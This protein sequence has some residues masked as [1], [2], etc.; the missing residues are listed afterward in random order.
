MRPLLKIM[1]ALM[2]VFIGIFLL[3]NLTGIVTVTRI[4][5]WLA[6]ARSADPFLVGAIVAALLLAD[7]I[8]AVPTMATLLLAGYF[9]G[10]VN[11]ALAGSVGLLAAGL[12]GYGLGR[13]YGD[14][15]VLRLVGGRKEK[16][17]A[18]RAF[19]R[20][21]PVMI[22]LAR[23]VP[24]LPEVS[25]CMAGV[26]GMPFFRFLGLWLVNVVPYCAVAAYAGSLSSLDDPTP[27][28]ATALGMSAFLW[29]AW[30]LFNRQQSSNSVTR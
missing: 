21:G 10:A 23:A 5:A 2:L 7:L 18:V 14:A 3:L 20:H 9:I 30:A 24:M 13:R 28:V 8:I 27:A 19:Q 12:A 16:E 1:G 17:K 6:A 11:G 25:A 15:A 22:V 29:L 4:E 26:S